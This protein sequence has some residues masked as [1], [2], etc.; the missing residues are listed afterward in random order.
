MSFNTKALREQ[1][2]TLCEQMKNLLKTAHDENRSLTADERTNFDKLDADQNTLKVRID[3]AAKLDS[4]DSE[5]RNVPT[6][7]DIPRPEVSTA[8]C[9]D[10]WGKG[11]RAWF[12]Q[13]SPR[14]G[15]TPQEWRD[16]ASRVGLNLH[17]KQI[18]LR[19]SAEA[20]RS[21]REARALTTQTGSSGG[22]TIPTTLV[23]ELEVALLQFNGVRQV[24][25][26]LR[27]TSG[28]D[29]NYPTANDTSNKGALI[30]ENS[31]TA[32][33]V[34][35]TFGTV[36]LKGYTFTSKIIRVPFQLLMDNAVNLESRLG[37][38]LGERIGRIQSQYFSTGTGTSEPQ[39]IVTAAAAGVTAAAS[40]AIA[41]SDLVKLF[42][43]V[44]PAYRDNAQWMMADDTVSQVK[45]IVDGIGRPL[46][47]PGL[48]DGT[49]DKIMGKAFTVNQEMDTLSGS[50]HTVS[51]IFGALSKHMIR[52]VGDV[53]LI[54][55]DE[56]Y[57]EYGQVA[58]VAW[59]RGDS[60]L[61]D[62]GTH[63][64]KKLT[65]P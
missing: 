65:H 11:L 20:P 14:G 19:I 53:Q 49:P 43:S 54:R 30:S 27:T 4:L 48:A 32:D 28:E 41:Y 26:I 42:H 35:P 16:S 17:S 24:A 44:D 10:D 18:S 47:V 46:W 61:L 12:L 7:G 22:A 64:V 40:N 62:A 33:N 5:L 63:P 15:E 29:L 56:R 21:L 38:M 1:R 39:G 52:D 8:N 34:D 36:T 3:D 60:K 57:A 23:K 58:F 37:Q 13:P 6:G 45:Q 9:S 51:V 2:G 25:S 50:T 59:M 31:A 55:L